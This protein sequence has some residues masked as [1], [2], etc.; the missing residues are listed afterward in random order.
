MALTVS[1][2]IYPDELAGGEDDQGRRTYTQIF[3]V[4]QT[5]AGTL[6]AG[7][8]VAAAAQ[9]V[10]TGDAVPLRGDNYSFPDG[11]IDTD[12]FVLSFAWRRPLPNAEPKRWHITVNYGPF[13]GDPGQ[14]AESDPLLWPTE[15]WVEW[16]EVSEVI[17]NA[18]NV[19]ALTQIGRAA[20]TDGPIVNACGQ[21][22]GEPLMRSVYYPIL[23]CQ[24]AYA[25]LEEIIALNDTYQGTTNNGTF[26]GA[27]ARKAKYVHTDNSKLQRTQGVAYYLG[28]TKILINKKTWDRKI[29][30]NGWSHF[31]KS[32]ASTYITGDAGLPYGNPFQ[33]A[34][35]LIR[36]LAFDDKD[37]DTNDVP[38]SEPMN[39][40]LDG[41]L[42]AIG[43]LSEKIT[44]RDLEEVDYAGIG[45]GS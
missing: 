43:S 25:T 11:T 10:M 41:T 30:N 40:K 44:Y 42:V 7:V 39:L 32:D 37:D 36:N 4:D 20:D 9:A 6:A 45:I 13:V 15:Y 35:K 29:I 2:K 22:T 24:K 28:T 31:E 26:F 23:C 17:E 16:Y 1:S 14:L 33:S 34:P 8:A 18:K 21:E 27:T 38:C 5:D 12:A 19:E 3:E